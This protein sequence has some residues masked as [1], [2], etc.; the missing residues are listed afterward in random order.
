MKMSVISKIDKQMYEV[1]DITYD[2]VGYPH[3]L[4]YQDNRWVRMSAK[5]FRP[6][7]DRDLS[8]LLFGG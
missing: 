6:L 8:S 3:F 7:E 1:F 2:S 5:Y 4:I